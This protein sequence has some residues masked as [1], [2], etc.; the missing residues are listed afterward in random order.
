VAHGAKDVIADIPVVFFQR[1]QQVL[2][3]APAGR[4]ARGA[5]A[6]TDR[7]SPLC[8]VFL[9]QVLPDIGQRPDNVH[10][11]A[12][13]GLVR[14]HRADLP[15]VE[16]IDEQG[17]DD[18]V[19]VMGESDLVKAVFACDLEYPL[20]PEARTE[21]AG[22]LAVVVAVRQ[23]PDVGLLHLIPVAFLHEIFLQ[24]PVGFIIAVEARIDID[25]HHRKRRD[26][27]HGRIEQVQKR[28]AVLAAGDADK[29]AVP[30]FDHPVIHDS[31][32]QPLLHV[33]EEACP[34][35][36]GSRFRQSPYGDH[37]LL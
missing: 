26:I 20:A 23:G 36:C 12:K 22:V 35:V 13:N 33:E 29:N 25:D 30:F 28:K 1:L 6:L 37:A 11:A 34:S 31:L 9:D 21:E 15:A 24:D 10:F 8:G 17:L 27:D 5:E 3:I 2:D 7:K 4:L 32:L 19:P 16:H 14:H 18:I